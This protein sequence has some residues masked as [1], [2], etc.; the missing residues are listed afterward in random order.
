M[1]LAGILFAGY[2]ALAVPSNLVISYVGAKAWLPILTVAWGIIAAAQAAVRC[3]NALIALRFFLGAAE[4]GEL[5]CAAPSWG[6]L[7]SASS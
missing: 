2:A 7:R 6:M 3:Q 4:A 5:F 1:L